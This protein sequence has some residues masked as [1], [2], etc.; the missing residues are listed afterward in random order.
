M[1]CAWAPFIAA[2]TTDSPTPAA[3]V[4]VGGAVAH[5]RINAREGVAVADEQDFHGIGG[6]GLQRRSEDP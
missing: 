2:G 5:R 1:A 4:D 3:T 6:S